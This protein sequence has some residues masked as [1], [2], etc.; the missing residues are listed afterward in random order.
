MDSGFVIST[1]KGKGGILTLEDNK[2]ML[3]EVID[4]NTTAGGLQSDSEQRRW[5][6]RSGF[7]KIYSSPSQILRLP[8]VPLLKN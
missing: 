2:A 5:A 6:E 4:W 1:R 8:P 7:L 3:N